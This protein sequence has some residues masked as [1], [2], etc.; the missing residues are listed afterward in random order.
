MSDRLFFSLAL[1]FAIVMIGGALSVGSG[2]QSCGPM[3]GAALGD[4]YSVVTIEARDLCRIE[5]GGES[6]LDLL[7]DKSEPNGVRIELEP[8]AA[9][10]LAEDNPHFKLGPDLEN[11]FKGRI[12]RVSFL[13]KPADKAGAV[14]IEAKYSAGKA[15][16]SG[17]QRFELQPG[18]Q[19]YSFDYEVPE[20]LV[21]QSNAF[22]YFSV[23]PVTAE[24]ARAVVIQKIIFEPGAAWGTP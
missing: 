22:D 23:R 20:K 19:T 14:A 6:E 24:K 5:A 18:W 2:K 11:V 10:E 15:G 16:D 4:D 3:G 17:W 21:D 1:V 13:A 8:D 12:I 7:G 9:R